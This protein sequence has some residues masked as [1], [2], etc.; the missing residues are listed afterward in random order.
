MKITREK[1]EKKKRIVKR[2]RNGQRQD[3]TARERIRFRVWRLNHSA[4]LTNMKDFGANVSD[5]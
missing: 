4:T 1:H 3:S 5:Q 2:N